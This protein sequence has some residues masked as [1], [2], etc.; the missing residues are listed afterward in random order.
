[1]SGPFIGLIFDVNT[2][3]ETLLKRSGPSLLKPVAGQAGP[4][5]ATLTVQG[6]K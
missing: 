5:L 6:T 1:M 4:T 2:P 3:P